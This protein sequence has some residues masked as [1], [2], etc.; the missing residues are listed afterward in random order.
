MSS[1]NAVE[2]IL[3][4][5]ATYGQTPAPAA[6]VAQVIR[7]TT[8]SLSGTPTTTTSQENRVDRMSG[9]QIVTGLEVGGA[10]NGELSADPAYQYLFKLGM[11]KAPVAA[12]VAIGLS[13]GSLTKDPVNPQLAT[14]A[15]PSGD[16]NAAFDPGDMVLL[17]GLDDAANNGPSQ[18]VSIAGGGLSMVVT[19]K[20]EAV[21]D[22][23]LAVAAEVERPAFLDIGSTVFSATLSKA[24]T[25]VLHALTTDQHS[26][27]YAGSIVNGFSVAL[28]YGEIATVVFNT[29]ANGYLQEAPSLRQQIEDASGTITP[30]GTA[31]P[32]NASIDMGMVTID[33]AP[34][35]F[36]IETLSIALDNGNTPQNCLGKAAPTRYNVGTANIT[37]EASIYLAC[38]SYDAFMPA[39]LTQEPVGMFFAAGNADGGFAFDLRAV[40]LSFPDPAVTGQNAPVMIDAAGVAKVGDGGASALRVYYW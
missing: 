6:A 17:S 1:A 40:Q 31:A 4:P 7:F 34:T 11:M 32:L 27:R 15:I 22:A 18:I 21:D 25:D 33:G 28:S 30:A 20:R 19:T 29:L 13:G 12:S 36:C 9:G 8:E 5:E 35:E 24:Y 16:F 26:Q 37:V 3:V 14:L 10:I 39:K 23:S 38:P 2:L